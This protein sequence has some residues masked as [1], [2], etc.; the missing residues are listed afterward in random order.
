MG[1]IVPKLADW[2]ATA[3]FVMIEVHVDVFTLDD[4]CGGGWAVDGEVPKSAVGRTGA[5]DFEVS[6]ALP[7]LGVVGTAPVAESLSEDEAQ[8]LGIQGRFLL[9]QDSSCSQ[10]GPV[11]KG[12]QAALQ[13]GIGERKYRGLFRQELGQ[14]EIRMPRTQLWE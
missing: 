2:G 7:A 13:A 9:L 11:F 6:L 5:F 3:G 1:E 14:N 4:G 10:I 12:G 8:E